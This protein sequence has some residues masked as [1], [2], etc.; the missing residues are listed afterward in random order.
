MSCGLSTGSPSEDAAR[1]HELDHPR[2]ILELPA[3]RRAALLR[4]VADAALHTGRRN[5]IRRKGIE[6]GMAAAGADGVDGVDHARPGHRAALDGVAQADVEE[7]RDPRSRTVVNP[8]S[9]VRRAYSAA[10]WACSVRPAEQVVHGVAVPARARLDREVRVRV[11]QA[12]EERDVAEDRSPA[13]RLAAC[14][15]PARSDL[16]S[17]PRARARRR[18]RCARRRGAPPGARPDWRRGA[19][20]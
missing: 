8:A 4:A 9:S 10:Y 6:I 14:R 16:H 13:R 19:R 15:R 3:H 7:F 17:P 20:R 1:G 2:A 12:R 5:A 18:S 11:D